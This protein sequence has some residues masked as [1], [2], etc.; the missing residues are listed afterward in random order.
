MIY[1]DS[2]GTKERPGCILTDK[3]GVTLLNR[4]DL[5]IG[6]ADSFVF[7]R[8]SKIIVAGKPAKEMTLDF[9]ALGTAIIDTSGDFPVAVAGS[10]VRGATVINEGH[11]KVHT[12][13]LLKKYKDQI[14]DPD[15]PDRPY[16]YLRIVVMNAGVNCEVINK[17]RIDVYF[18]HD[19]SN[20]STIYVTTMSGGKG[21]S[22]LNYGTI[23]FHGNGSVNTRMRGMAT[24]GDNVT[25]INYGKIIADVGCL[26]DARLITTGGT[27][28]NV[29]NEGV[30]D[31][32]GP[33]RV[34]GMTR[35]GD[36]NLINNGSIS[37][38]TLDYP[39]ESG[40][41]KMCAGCA[42][43]EPLNES[44]SNITPMVNRGTINLKS[45]S[46][47]ATSADK[48]L[49]GMYLD[50]ASADAASLKPSVINEGIINVDSTGPV[51]IRAAE[52]GF[53]FNALSQL[54]DDLICPVTVGSW[55]TKLRDLSSTRDLFIGE[56][57]KVNYG[58][59]ELV[60]DRN[61][62]EED[63]R[64]VSIAPEDIFFL[65]NDAHR[66]EYVNYEALKVCAADPEKY[67]AQ[68]DTAGM[69]VI[70]KRKEES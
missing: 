10:P 44:R 64:E 42:M 55:K 21:S 30:M 41:K 54:P 66:Y 56:G 35:Y 11:I 3:S 43:F 2:C 29:I 19:E 58:A 5:L 53:I 20:R 6:S 69:T 15:H 62:K 22:V 13:H 51:K 50:I 61:E 65:V 27:R 48:L 14:Q 60:F 4:D 52:A 57:V 37:I 17:G 24:F 67:E 38:T 32:K 59:A 36:S 40:I 18:D 1:P 9:A 70:L 63:P 16:K 31:I 28:A 33:G 68:T 12:K 39:A 7:G 34:I 49:L 45:E 26:D 8:E 25:C 46:S 47:E 23:C